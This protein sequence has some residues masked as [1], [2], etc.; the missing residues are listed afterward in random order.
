MLLKGQSSSQAMLYALL[1]S[2]CESLFESSVA[3]EMR[4]KPHRR[5]SGVLEAAFYT[6]GVESWAQ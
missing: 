1:S 4:L 6:S 2:G 3:S 5:T